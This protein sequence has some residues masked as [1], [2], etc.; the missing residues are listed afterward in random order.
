MTPHTIQFDN[1]T[2]EFNWL[3]VLSE[4]NYDYGVI[5]FNPSSKI[6]NFIDHGMCETIDGRFLLIQPYSI[7]SLD[8]SYLLNH[9]KIGFIPVSDDHSIKILNG[10]IDNE[11]STIL[12]E[13]RKSNNK[14][15][16]I[17]FNQSSTL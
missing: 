6:P 14:L 2:N 17:V 12:K 9:F 4:V 15:T 13:N 1:L 11:T 8:Q 7:R 3:D 5:F 10:E 16:L